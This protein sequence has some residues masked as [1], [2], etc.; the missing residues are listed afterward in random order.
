[1]GII[2][3]EHP[4]RRETNEITYLKGDAT[5]PR[6]EGPKIIAQIVND[7]ALNWGGGVALAARKKWPA[8]QEVYR[9][10]VLQGPANLRLGNTHTAQVERDLWLVSLVA[11]HGYG[12]SP[13]PR[14]RYAALGRTLDQVRDIAKQKKATVHMP[15]IG[16]GQAGGSWAIIQEMI[17]EALCRNNVQV[18]VYDLP[19]LQAAQ[20][21]QPWLFGGQSQREV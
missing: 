15:R 16:A 11:Q 7:K 19:G 10:W 12:P 14:I 17:D 3:P 8:V 2:T 6:G 9:R 13:T 4:D 1:V 20:Q 18:F 21:R 5:V